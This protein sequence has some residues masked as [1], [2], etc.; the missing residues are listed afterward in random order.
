MEINLTITIIIAVGG[1]AF[2]IYQ[3]FKNRQ[4]EKKDLLANRRYEEYSRFM[5]KLEQIN[6]SVRK[7][8][9]LIFGVSNDFIATLLEGDEE[10]MEKA[11][12]TYNQRIIDY[13]RTSTEPLLIINQEI[14]PLLLIASDDLSRLLSRYKELINDFNNEIQNCLSKLSAKNSN[15]FKV[16]ETIGHNERWK[17][18]STINDDI[19]Q[20]MRK[21]I[22]VKYLCQLSPN[23]K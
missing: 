10:S 19:L 16:L 8:P 2:G 9:N 17:E 15:S 5:R 7:D 12:L 21:E 23:R 18:Y 22:N 13:I 11:L 20:L 6:E 3:M 4:W 14:S 1:W